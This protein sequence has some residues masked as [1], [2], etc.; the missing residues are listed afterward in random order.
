MDTGQTNQY[1]SVMSQKVVISFLFMVVGSFLAGYF[2]PWWGPAVYIILHTA[3]MNLTVRQGMVSGMLALSLVYLVM[4]IWMNQQDHADVVEKT[5]TVLGGLRP[6]ALI[7]LTV[8]IGC[9]TGLFS[10][11]LGSA[12][13]RYLMEQNKSKA[14]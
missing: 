7:L 6:M 2:G 13:R 12:F 10:G 5:G 4:S 3:L 11:W 9:L 14:Q 1:P 8:L